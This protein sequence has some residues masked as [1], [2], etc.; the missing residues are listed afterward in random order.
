MKEASKDVTVGEH[1]FQIG[2]VKPSDGTWLIT[3]V[4]QMFSMSPEQ[5]EEFQGVCLSYCFF[6]QGGAHLMP[7]YERKEKAFTKPCEFMAKDMEIVQ[8]LCKE[9]IDFNIGDFL[10]KGPE[11]A[12]SSTFAAR[13][14]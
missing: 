1:K 8:Q 7:V 11:K 14:L 12:L 2:R 9:V 5:M 10:A 6:F 3:R 13:L 4:I